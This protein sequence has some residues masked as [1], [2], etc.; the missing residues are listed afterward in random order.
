MV[1]TAAFNARDFTLLTLGVGRRGF[2]SAGKVSV[3]P[4]NES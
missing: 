4:V 2:V 1:A 3:L